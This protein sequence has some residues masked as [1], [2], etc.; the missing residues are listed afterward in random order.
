MRQLSRNQTAPTFDTEN[1]REKQTQ[2]KVSPIT[3]PTFLHRPTVLIL[4]FRLIQHLSLIH[5]IAA[6]WKS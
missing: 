5:S 1:E 6:R 3:G 2:V 4:V